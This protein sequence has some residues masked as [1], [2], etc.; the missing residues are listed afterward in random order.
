MKGPWITW[1]EVQVGFTDLWA[2]RAY[3]RNPSGRRQ[4]FQALTARH[5][6][7]PVTFLEAASFA[8]RRVL[9]EQGCPVAR[10]LHSK[11]CLQKIPRA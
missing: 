11:I 2:L 1:A 8:S 5:R 7:Q 9:Q 4:S 6:C 10:K 3:G